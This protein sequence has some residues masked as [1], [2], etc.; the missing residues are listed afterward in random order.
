MFIETKE[1]GPQGLVVERT[2]DAFQ[3]PLREGEVVQIDTVHLNGELVREQDGFSFAGDIGTV[4][5]LPCSRCLET[6]NLPL[7]LHFHL[8]YTT[9]PEA[10]ERGESRVDE[11]SITVNQ[12]D[13]QRIDLGQLL[14]EQVYLGLP[15][16]PLCSADCH[17][18][19]PRCGT[20]LNQVACGCRE[21]RAEDP[22]LLVLKKLL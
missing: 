1:I 8:A 16:K 20:N 4:A 12:F 6:Y 17:G 5:T 11:D 2:I 15:L 22:R 7:D 3:L 19:C 9:R 18:L 10:L 13:G 21:E 14:S